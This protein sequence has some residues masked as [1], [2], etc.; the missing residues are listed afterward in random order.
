MKAIGVHCC[1]IE[2]DGSKF[3]EN[4]RVHFPEIMNGSPSDKSPKPIRISKHET[5]NKNVQ[6]SILVQCGFFVALELFTCEYHDV[7]H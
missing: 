7:R 2:S 4:S 3:E 6:A 5:V 1:E